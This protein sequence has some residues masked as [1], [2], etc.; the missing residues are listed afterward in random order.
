MRF[1][2]KGGGGG[3]T[4]PLMLYFALYF[5]YILDK[6]LFLASFLSPAFVCF[7]PSCNFTILM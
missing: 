6:I 5:L 7:L 2:E 4:I 1:F 3:F